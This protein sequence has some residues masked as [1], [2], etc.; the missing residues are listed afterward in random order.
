MLYSSMCNAIA[1]SRYSAIDVSMWNSKTSWLIILKY[2]LPKILPA[3]LNIAS[4]L[5]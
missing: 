4:Y 5:S 2:K 3:I 1:V